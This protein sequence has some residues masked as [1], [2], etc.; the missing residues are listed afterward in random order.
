MKTKRVFA[1]LLAVFMIS[2]IFVGCKTDEVVP[3][4]KAA[5]DASASST[6]ADDAADETTGLTSGG[7]PISAEGEFPIVTEP[8]TLK[9]MG[10]RGG[11]QGPWEEMKLFQAWQEKTGV[12][13]DI[14]T[15]PKD[16][17][18]EKKNLAFASGDLPDFFYAG[19][20]NEKDEMNYG[21]QGMLL[22]LNDLIEEHAPNL[23]SLFEDSPEVRKA[24]TTL[25]GNIYSL[26]FID[27]M[28][29]NLTQK[30]WI[31]TVWLERVGKEVPTTVDEFY[32]VLVAF[33][34]EDPNE[35]GLADEI[36]LS[37]TEGGFRQTLSWW[38]IPSDGDFRGNRDGEVYYAAMEPEYKEH[39]AFYN[40]LYEEG[41]VD[42]EA[43]TQTGQQLKAKGK[44]EH[45]ILG[46][47]R[48]AGPFIVVT[49]EE[50]EDYI[51]L[52]PLVAAD[53]SQTWP[54]S[55]GVKR[56]AFAM[57]SMNEYPEITIK[58]IDWVYEREG[59]LTS[60]RG[61]AGEDFIYTN[62]EETECE[63]VIPEGY[64]SFEEY[65]AKKLTPNS[66]CITPGLGGGTLPVV[67]NPLND[68]ID[69]QVDENLVPYWVE[70]YPQ[71]YLEDA[72][73]KEVA[74][75]N[76]DINPYVI[77]MSARFIT[78]DLSLEKDYD[79]F[80]AELEKMGVQRYIDIYQKAYD[81]WANQ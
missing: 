29:R 40:K 30:V 58:L 76:A 73:Q 2:G 64:A 39:L 69:D 9:V 16:N 10:A 34:N 43:F 55:S 19:Y 36:P 42:N 12:T 44:E 17:W 4:S 18:E 74:T 5:D 22:P 65:R 11:A 33:K 25:D 70:P 60:M 6:A 45:Q 66:G 26:P 63:L 1:L 24:I 61:I 79:N 71:V 51:A 27:D 67:H 32:D 35:N 20:I 75:I 15:A 14:T 68:W 31:N 13:F 37:W 57:T 53:G 56:G 46:S 80:I 41:L 77:E 62:A 7:I 50:N 81:A 72:D 52:P 38:G 48:E 54:T 47:F 78:G 21:G 49:N 3:E 28:N 8:V 59:A 23:R